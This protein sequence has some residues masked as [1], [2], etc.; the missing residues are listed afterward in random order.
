MG[1]EKR[2]TISSPITRDLYLFIFMFPFY[3]TCAIQVNYYLAPNALY[4]IHKKDN[5]TGIL[6]PSTHILV[7]PCGRFLFLHV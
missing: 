2:T 3:D 7:L 4:Y 5:G 6:P 1:Y